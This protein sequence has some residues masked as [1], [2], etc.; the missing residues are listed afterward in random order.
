MNC[1]CGEDISFIIA[2]NLRNGFAVRKCRSC[3]TENMYNTKEQ[4]NNTIKSDGGS[5]SYYDLKLSDKTVAFIQEN[6]YVK[7]E[8]LIMD[9]FDN[10]FDFANSFKSLV[11]AYAIVKGRGKEGNDIPY[12]MNKIKYSC[13]KIKEYRSIKK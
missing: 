11:R 9:I 13:D 3:G 7:T 5:S 12:E 8:H 2:Q 6:E 4:Q 10:D 1:R